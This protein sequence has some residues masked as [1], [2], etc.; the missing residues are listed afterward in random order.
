MNKPTLEELKKAISEIDSGHLR[1]V[2]RAIWQRLIKERKIPCEICG[3]T[4]RTN[5]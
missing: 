3:E 1:E 5:W 2:Y 4:D